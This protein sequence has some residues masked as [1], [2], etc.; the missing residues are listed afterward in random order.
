[1]KGSTCFGV[2]FFVTT[3]IF[4][5]NGLLRRRMLRPDIYEQCLSAYVQWKGFS[6]L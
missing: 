6:L 3:L 1:M 4:S 2:G 5:W